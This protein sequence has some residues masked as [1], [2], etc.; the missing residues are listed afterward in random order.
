MII[1]AI[2]KVFIE[3][4]GFFFRKHKIITSACLIMISVCLIGATSRMAKIPLAERYDIQ[5]YKQYIVKSGDT[6][7]GISSRYAPNSISL[8]RFYMLIMELSDK[9]NEKLMPG[10][11]IIIPIIREGDNN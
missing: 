7:W 1:W 4:I 2:I 6:L 9:D 10:E 5:E 11:V 3:K 8:D